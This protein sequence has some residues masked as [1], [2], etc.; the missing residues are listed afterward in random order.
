[1]FVLMCQTDEQQM[2]L[3]LFWGCFHKLP[4]IYI[5]AVG[6][7]DHLGLLLTHLTVHV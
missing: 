7:K 4:Q 6:A 5:Q 1:M 2:S 3:H